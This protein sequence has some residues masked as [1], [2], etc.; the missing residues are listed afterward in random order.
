MKTYTG[1]E[2]IAYAVATDE[3][4]PNTLTHEANREKG[5]E[6]TKL[7]LEAMHNLIRPVSVT[8]V[9]TVKLKNH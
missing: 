6:S 4:V 2:V 9:H 1:K 3:L 8:D 5:I 7:M